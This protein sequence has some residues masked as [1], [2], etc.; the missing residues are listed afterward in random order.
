MKKVCIL[1]ALF[2]YT[3]TAVFAQSLL[4]KVPANASM[5]IKY[6]GENFKTLVPTKKLDTYGFIRKEFFSMLNVDTLTSIENMGI[7]FEQDSYQ[8]ITTIDSSLSFVTI[9]KTLLSSYNL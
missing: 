7:N 9:L 2:F 6:A 3:A 4:T 5:V 8:Y 1:I